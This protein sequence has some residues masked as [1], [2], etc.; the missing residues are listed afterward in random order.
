MKKKAL[1]L[2]GAL[3]LASC[4]SLPD[5]RPVADE[6]MTCPSPFLAKTTRFIHAIEVRRSGEMQAAMIGVTL[7]DPAQRTISCALM[8]PE[9][10]AFLEA[11]SGPD[12]LQ[13]SRAL[14]PFDSLDF[15][16]NMMDDIEMIF[17]MPLETPLQKGISDAGEAVCR[18]H[19][20][21]GG[22]LDVLAGLDGRIRII[23]YSESGRLQRSV[24]LA[25]QADNPYAAI[26][27]QAR[28]LFNYSLG[29]TLIES[30]TIQD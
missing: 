11:V 24:T 2:I 19:K 18:R 22:W 8:S 1:L 15:V 4:A 27:L 28:D 13:V 7:T 21:R 29:M 14:P 10:M 16:R 12:D 5:I 26:D 3:L 6:K 30:E 23:Q 9:G 20:Q 25:N 17:L